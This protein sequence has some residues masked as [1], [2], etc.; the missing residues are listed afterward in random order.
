[1]Y[2]HVGKTILLSVLLGAGLE[3]FR[4]SILSGVD[5][6]TFQGAL[7]TS[8]ILGLLFLTLLYLA[9]KTLRIK[10]IGDVLGKPIRRKREW[11]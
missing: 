3:G 1:M 2:R 5:R 9:G 10:E 6:W 8:S 4:R 11:L 7:F